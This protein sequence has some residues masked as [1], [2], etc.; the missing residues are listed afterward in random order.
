MKTRLYRA[1]PYMN[2]D[3]KTTMLVVAVETRYETFILINFFTR[4][5][6]LPT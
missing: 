4:E 3:I 6:L 5:N 1:N 2:N